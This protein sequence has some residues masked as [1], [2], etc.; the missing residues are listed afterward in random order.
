[1]VLLKEWIGDSELH[2]DLGRGLAEIAAVTLEPEIVINES[3]LIVENEQQ[4]TRQDDE[5]VGTNQSDAISGKGGNDEISGKG[6][7]DS[8]SGGGG[9]D[10]LFGGG[11][12]DRLFGE[13][14]ADELS[15]GGGDDLLRGGDGNDKIRGD[16]GQDV[17]IGG[18]G[19]DLLVGDQGNDVFILETGAGEDTIRDFARN[20]DK[21]GLPGGVGF[22][23]LDLTL[24]G[25][26]TKTIISLNGSKLAELVGILPEQLSA[27]DFAPVTFVV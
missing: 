4:G 16:R 20:Q 2:S 22:S 15:G 25:C 11:G 7:T 12:D 6:G 9:T 10:G 26:G 24:C 13:A 21:L 17:L 1:M 23:D 14:G 3:P 18:L 5:L 27:S 8:L 19:D